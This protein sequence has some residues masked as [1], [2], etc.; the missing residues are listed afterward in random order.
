MMNQWIYRFL[1]LRRI[2]TLRLIIHEELP[3]EESQHDQTNNRTS[4]DRLEVLH[5]ELVLHG[6]GLLLKLST[7]ILQSISSLLQVSQLPVPLQ[8]I[9]HVLVHDPDHLVHLG[10]LL[11][12]PPLGHH[13][14]HLLGPGQGLAVRPKGPAIRPGLGGL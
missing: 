14:L 9:L 12:H 8:H 13:L 7:P 5:P 1:T 2:S 11:G 4:D 3:V 6:S 10:L